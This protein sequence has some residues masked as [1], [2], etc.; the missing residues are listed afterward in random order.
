M[1]DLN[2]FKDKLLSIRDFKK[3]VLL[4]FI[5]KRDDELLTEMGLSNDFI[6]KLYKKCEKIFKL[7]MEDYDSHVKN[8][9]E[10]VLEELNNY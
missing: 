1:E 6:T 7:E 5:I 10:S 3:I 8:L 2:Y 9:E 4:I